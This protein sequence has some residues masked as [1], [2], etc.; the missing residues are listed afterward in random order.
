MPYYKICYHHQNKNYSYICYEMQ[1]LLQWKHTKTYEIGTTTVADIGGLAVFSH[2]D[3]VKRFIGL[4][5]TP[6]KYFECECN[7]EIDI[8][9]N[10]CKSIIHL[11]SIFTNCPYYDWP[12]G[13]RLFKNVSLIREIKPSEIWK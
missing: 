3:Y 5:V 2:I 9:T 4:H 11:H 6:L 13:T 7:E 8:N 1:S 12:I 10:K